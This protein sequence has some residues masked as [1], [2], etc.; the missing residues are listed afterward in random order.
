MCTGC[1][2]IE[3]AEKL[4]LRNNIALYHETGTGLHHVPVKID[5]LV[6]LPVELLKYTF[7]LF[8]SGFVSKYSNVFVN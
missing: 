4:S 8:A 5:L 2:C 3:A 1:T 7:Q 6:H